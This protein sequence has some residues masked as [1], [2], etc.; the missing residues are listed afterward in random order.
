MNYPPPPPPP[1]QFSSPKKSK[2][3]LIAIAVI[4]IVVVAAVIG[5]YVY[6]QNGTNKPSNHTPTTNPTSHPTT[7]IPT[8]TPSTSLKPQILSS[9]DYV[10]DLGYYVIVGEVKNTLSSNVDYVKII[11]T[12]YDSSH[13]VIGTEYTYTTVDVLKSNQ[14][15]P[16]ELSSY[17]DKINPASYTL[18][19]DYD[20]TDT[21]PFSGLT[22]LSNTP[23][24]DSLG[25][26]NIVGEVKNNG[27]TEA[28][29]VK[30]IGTYYDSIGKV[31]GQSF[32]YSTSDTIAV[33]DT[34][35][36]ELSSYPLMIT[37]ARYELQIQ[38]R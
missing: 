8:S 26:Y 7:S 24:T 3:S 30:I 9:S 32:T 38:G 31:V 23:S 19:L 16:F 25:Y 1:Q 13:T 35:P 14:K 12:Y 18:T 2:K 6:S 4:A 20:V 21:E 10:D 34:S 17:P 37:P 5:V 33:G 29:Y 27:V 28:S 36:F 15:S 11:A 22:I